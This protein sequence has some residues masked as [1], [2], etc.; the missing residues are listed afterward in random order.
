MSGTPWSVKG[1]DSKAREVAKDLARRSGMTLG[2]WLNQ[3]I[4]RGEDVEAII[5]SERQKSARSSRPSRPEP[6]PVYDEADDLYFEDEVAPEPVRRAPA[7]A[8]AP[9]RPAPYSP[10][11]QRERR[12]ASE[13]YYDDGAPSDL[14]R[15][16]RV[17]DTLGTRIES[18]EM[19]S[20][21]AVRGVSQAVES[22]LNRLERS[23]ASL[24]ETLA[25]SEARF[26]DQTREVM[27]SVA[28]SR[29]WMS[30]AETDRSALSD[31]VDNAEHLMDAQAERLEGLSGHLREARERVAR[32]EAEVQSSPAKDAIDAVEGAV[33]RLS[34][35]LYEN[36][37]RARET[38]KDVRGDMVGLSHR[39]TQ[40][41]LRDPDASA[42]AIVD[43]VVTQF[44]QRLEAAEARTSTAMRTLEQAFAALDARLI[45]A[46]AQGDVTDPES[47]QTLSRLSA[48]FNRRVDEAR[49]EVLRLLDNGQKAT[50]DETLAA[51]D[52]RLSLAETRQARAIETLGQDVLKI[53]EN[54]N[55]KVAAV[56]TSSE[57]AMGRQAADLKRLN[58]SVDARLGAADAGHAQAL[59]R[60]SG[61]IARISESL[62]R[63]VAETERRTAQVLEG[64]GEELDTRHQRVHSDIADRIRQSEERTQKLLE[65]AR[66]KIDARL[67]QAQTHTLLR[68]ASRQETSRQAETAAPAFAATEL[69]Q[70]PFSAFEHGFDAVEGA[71]VASTAESDDDLTGR[72]LA[73]V[74]NFS[75]DP[76]EAD[77]FE[78]R[79][80]TDPGALDAAVFDD[81]ATE[82]ERDVMQ[83][84]LMPRAADP[85]GED[86]DLD[87]FADVDASRKLSPQAEAVAPSP[88]VMAEEPRE[89]PAYED[90]S[91][92]MST[93]D[94]LAA[95]RAA[96][97][98]SVEGA[99]DAGKPLS[100]LRVG[101]SRTKEAKPKAAKGKNK[102]LL[103]AFK[104]SSVAVILTAGAVGTYY[105]AR[106]KEEKAPT[107][108]ASAV[109]TA[110]AAAK[111]PKILTP[112][113]TTRLKAMYQSAQLA[114]EANDPKSI[115]AMRTVADLGYPQAQFQMSVLYDQG[116]EGLVAAD[117]VQARRWA[118][119]AA[120]SGNAPAMYNLGLMNY[121][122]D[123]GP[124]DYNAA[125]SWLRKSAEYGVRDGQF[126]IGVMYM[127][128]QVVAE[129]PTEA[130]K[131]LSIA[132]N[133][134][135]REAEGMLRELRGRLTPEQLASATAAAKAFTPVAAADSAALAT[136]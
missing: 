41:E 26:S 3:M 86:F 100:G 9:R 71:P 79:T 72:L 117:K 105:L 77:P 98:A 24:A 30:R 110:P 22:L 70:K 17:L 18:S 104:A 111:T 124:A 32:L 116:R 109:T 66:S 99:S 29:E 51:V 87:P 113:E 20:A 118:E 91:V 13:P 12:A 75:D 37:M 28:S 121:N 54:L 97:R 15:M 115:D 88:K 81:V 120:Q 6:A 11:A 134:G 58:A 68:E 106:G 107:L 36:D 47:V 114:L 82:D 112:E 59:E 85:F 96:V 108:A 56:Q 1:I 74:T 8:E 102:T 136:R 78:T 67:G 119:R 31:R 10:A 95:A 93:R 40:L 101:A 7:R 129:N 103:N 43:R 63:K 80:A 53:A 131:W 38:V 94:A 69:Q 14:G 89:R 60:L 45:R 122:G 135:D 50:L 42:Q 73:P 64:V 55:R 83:A 132:A 27:D 16:V 125:A 48:D 84:P 33:G 21:S 133:N 123:G 127:Q 61:E 35:Q 92:S 90:N 76:F 4:L 46:E 62:N 23:E 19:R 126:G 52:A 34:N 65:E 49:H 2:E 25:D 128:G 5:R 57:E 130:Y 44:S 39:L